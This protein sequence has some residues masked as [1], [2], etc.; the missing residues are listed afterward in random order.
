MKFLKLNYA[1]L[2]YKGGVPGGPVAGGKNQSTG[3]KTQSTGGKI[4]PQAAKTISSPLA[5]WPKSNC[6]AS[7]GS[8]AAKIESPDEP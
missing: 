1:T 7:P 6:P 8:P 3:G 4:N 2:F 5:F